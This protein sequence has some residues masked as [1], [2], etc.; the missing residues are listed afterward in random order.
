MNKQAIINKLFK[1][2]N[3]INEQSL[4][5]SILEDLSE[6][7]LETNDKL[8]KI[9][10]ITRQCSQKHKSL[11]DTFCKNLIFDIIESLDKL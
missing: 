8:F 11:K 3:I 5:L 9:Y 1:L 2:E 6:I 7:S 4:M 10:V